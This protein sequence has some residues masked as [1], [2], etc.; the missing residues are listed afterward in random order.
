MTVFS[1]FPLYQSGGSPI[2]PFSAVFKRFSSANNIERILSV[3][4]VYYHVNG[5]PVG[6]HAVKM[7]GWGVENGTKYWLC[8]NSWSSEWGDGGFFKIKMGQCG[9]E[10]QIVTEYASLPFP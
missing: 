1:D 3:A 7:I 5:F 2:S 8:A 6:Q 10:N 9:I 4:G